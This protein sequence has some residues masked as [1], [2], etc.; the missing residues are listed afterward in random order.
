MIEKIKSFLAKYLRVVQRNQVF[1]VILLVSAVL[2]FS[3]LR[4]RGYLDPVRNEE[5]FSEG[6][7]KI[8]YSTIDQSIIDEIGATLED[9]D[10]EVDSNF[11]PGRNNP[12]AE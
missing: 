4:S 5:R 7:L 3:L 10:I 1:I 11:E 6:V 12:F 2:I 9:K 8:K